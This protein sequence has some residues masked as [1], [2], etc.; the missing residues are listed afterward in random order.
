MSPNKT[1][2]STPTFFDHYQVIIREFMRSL[3][4]TT[5]LKCE[6]SCVVMRQH[7]IQ[8]IYVMFGVVRRAVCRLHETYQCRRYSRKLL[9]M[10]REV[11]RNM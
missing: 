4:K 2:K 1:L 9:M 10:D 6:Y 7:N 11:A 5:E 3:L 8:C